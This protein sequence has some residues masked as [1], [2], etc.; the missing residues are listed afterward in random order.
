MLYQPVSR[1]PTTTTATATSADRNTTTDF[2]DHT[3][4]DTNP[5][6]STWSHLCQWSLLRTCDPSNNLH[7][8]LNLVKHVIITATNHSNNIISS[9]VNYFFFFYYTIIKFISNII[10]I[11][12]IFFI[13]SV[14]SIIFFVNFRK[15]YFSEY[16]LLCNTSLY[17]L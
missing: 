17:E 16:L 10:C 4:N 2:S 9:F 15:Y 6:R 11:R 13:N 8:Q 12:I 7:M 5:S 1:Q 3:S 14:M